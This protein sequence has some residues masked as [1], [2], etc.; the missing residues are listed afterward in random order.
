MLVLSRQVGESLII[1][2]NIE[3][4]IVDIQGGNVKIGIDAPRNISIL[5]K[6]L[7]DEAKKANKQAASPNVDIADLSK[8]LLKK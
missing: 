6:E 1:G 5:R 8:M 2:D 3:I 4:K 7:A